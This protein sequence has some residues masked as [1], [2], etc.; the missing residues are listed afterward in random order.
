VVG[1]LLGRVRGNGTTLD[2]G[3]YVER[4]GLDDRLADAGADVAGVRRML[5]LT[6]AS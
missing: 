4:P 5:R 6:A 2:P 3:A 1:L